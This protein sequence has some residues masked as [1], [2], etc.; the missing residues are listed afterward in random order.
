MDELNV[1]EDKET[2]YV[3]F[4]DGEIVLVKGTKICIL[5]DFNPE[6]QRMKFILSSKNARK[7]SNEDKY[8]IYKLVPM[9][10]NM[11]EEPE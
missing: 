3:A 8:D 2:Q 9:G 5:R 11:K 6:E 10:N 7:L 4:V 1:K